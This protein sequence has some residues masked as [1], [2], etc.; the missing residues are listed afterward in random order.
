LHIPW[1]KA[2][3]YFSVR[4]NKRKSHLL[5]DRSCKYKFPMRRQ[6][7]KQIQGRRKTEL[8]YNVSHFHSNVLDFFI[9]PLHNI[10]QAFNCYL[11][12]RNINNLSLNEHSLCS[13]CH[14]SLLDSLMKQKIIIFKQILALS[15]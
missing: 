13:R 5:G 12:T 4:I 3:S 7:L 2:V 11:C 9:L 14:T 15:L 8:N 6:I 1:K 10:I